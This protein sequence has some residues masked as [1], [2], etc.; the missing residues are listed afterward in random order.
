MKPAGRPAA[1]A[2]AAYV[3]LVFFENRRATWARQS[4]G[5]GCWRLP[6][7]VAKV[8]LVVD[9]DER[10]WMRSSR[11]AIS[12]CCS[13]TGSESLRAGGRTFVAVVRTG[14]PGDEAVGIVLG[15]RNADEA[16]TS[17]PGV[18]E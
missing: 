10:R 15:G 11:G 7:G 8:A 5:R 13:F 17:M 4:A 6:P 2:G 3:G 12:D 16:L 1:A 14:L 9:A 18:A